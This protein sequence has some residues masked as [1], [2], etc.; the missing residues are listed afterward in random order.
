MESPEESIEEIRH[1]VAEGRLPNAM[2]RLRKFLSI[3]NGKKIGWRSVVTGLNAQLSDLERQEAQGTISNENAQTTRNRINT[4]F[5][6]V[7]EGIEKG[8]TA[9]KV[10]PQNSQNA[11]RWL[12]PT[13]AGLFVVAVSAWVGLQF[14]GNDAESPVDIEEPQ[15]CPAFADEN[16]LLKGLVLPYEPFGG[17]PLNI[18][19]LVEVKI[20]G[21][22]DQFNF[23]ADVKAYGL[24]FEEIDEYPTVPK[25]ADPIG[26]ACNAQ[27]VVFGQTLAREDENEVRTS[28]RFVDSEGW[29][30]REFGLNESMELDT[31][32]SLAQLSLDNTFIDGIEAAFR[33]IFGMSAHWNGQED[34]AIAL[35]KDHPVGPEAKDFYRIQQ[36]CLAEAYAAQNMTEEA[37]AAYSELI[38]VDPSIVTAWRNRS[39]LNYEGGHFADAVR[40]A[41]TAIG[42]GGDKEE[43]KFVRIAANIGRGNLMEAQ[44]ELFPAEERITKPNDPNAPLLSDEEMA[45]LKM[46]REKRE[47]RV[48]S[49]Q[50]QLA[51]KAAA[52]QARIE[53]IEE[54]LS[55]EPDN[56]ALLEEEAKILNNLGEFQQAAM[57]SQ[58]TLRIDPD[59]VSSVEILLDQAISRGDRK[60]FNRCKSMLRIVISKWKNEHFQN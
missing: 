6:K 25:D 53:E 55:N 3:G 60:E 42:A 17:D 57:V 26:Q 40:D 36:Q 48:R 12:L 45:R 39:V 14:A 9:P 49:L 10:T 59:N 15:A 8:E 28:F 44:M 7:L 5:L 13:L 31:V 50:E 35:M 43:L 4:Q 22:I 32:T 41:T 20:A 19:R 29:P 11:N 16:L 52:L 23:P 46:V 56:V 27:L 1:E 24:G 21:L 54:T 34:K 47:Q 58:K 37:I 51:L 18:Q 2:S 33:L 38:E 30:F